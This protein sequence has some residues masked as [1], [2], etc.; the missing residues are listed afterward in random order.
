MNVKEF[1]KKAGSIIIGVFAAIGA[2]LCGRLLRDKRRRSDDVRDDI[3]AAEIINKSAEDTAGRL[4]DKVQ[5]SDDTVNKLEENLRGTKDTIDKLDGTT[6]NLEQNVRECE[7]IISDIR[8]RG[9]KK[10]D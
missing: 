1:F 2:F 3:G 6:E 5:Q 10:K 4:E 8:K 7:D 9:K